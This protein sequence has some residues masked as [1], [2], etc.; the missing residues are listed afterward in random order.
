[1]E[2]ALDPDLRDSFAAA[3]AADGLSLSAYLRRAAIAARDGEIPPGRVERE[4][5]LAAERQLKRIGRNLNRMVTL[6]EMRRQ[7]HPEAP[8]LIAEL[9]PGA[10]A[11]ALDAVER[12]AADIRRQAESW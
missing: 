10:L 8:S 7:N 2:V 1:M 3:A 6:E 5:V 12:L 9:P 4:A 11:D